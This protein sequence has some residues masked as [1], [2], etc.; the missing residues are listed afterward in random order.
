HPYSL[1]TLTKA[2]HV[3]DLK[4]AENSYLYIDLAQN[5]L[6]SESFFYNYVEKYILKGRKFELE[7][8]LKP[9]E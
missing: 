1:E 4:E 6:G 3:P 2:T 8:K 5:A 9:L 7:F